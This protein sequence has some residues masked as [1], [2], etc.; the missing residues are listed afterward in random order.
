VD[1]KHRS[2]FRLDRESIVLFVAFAVLTV[3]FVTGTFWICLR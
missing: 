2:D 1:L 3:V